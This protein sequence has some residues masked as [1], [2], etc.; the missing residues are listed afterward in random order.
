M[1]VS[2][3][4]ELSLVL[5]LLLVPPSAA[6]RLPRA[7]PLVARR[8]A[9]APLLTLAESELA[10]ASSATATNA[11]ASQHRAG[12]VSIIGLPNVGKST[13]MNALVGEKLS[14]T[15][16]KAQ[17]TR[18]RI[19]GILSGDD[20]QIVYSDTPGVLI[21]QYKLQEGMMR[22]VQGSIND[23]DVI[24]V[25]VDIF[26]DSTFDEKLLRQLRSSTA[27]LLVL[28]NKVDL[29][30]D[31]E[32]DEAGTA[33]E[34]GSGAQ[35]SRRVTTNALGSQEELVARW[36]AEFDATVLPISARYG[37]GLDAVLERI[38]A[39]LPVHPPFYPKD[40]LSDKPEKFFAA[41][42]MREAIFGHYSQEIPYSCEVAVT[43]FK[44]GDEMIRI[45]CENKL[46]R[47]PR[48]LRRVRTGY[49]YQP[50]AL[51][52]YRRRRAACPRGRAYGTC[53]VH[54]PASGVRYAPRTVA[55][56]RCRWR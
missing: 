14:I 38:K 28:L 40:Q 5:L 25:V 4:R 8:V 37:E 35:R 41:E 26:Q 23:A 45:A 22:F 27:A 6:W 53:W 50:P 29:L 21:P 47:T 9:R 43:R 13:L 7:V 36:E 31:E 24:V 32:V 2:F 33:A 20:Y 3:A 15:C 52:T 44:E 16:S 55:P 10:T 19:M 39:L 51:G 30:P 12:F 11:A 48:G 56:W 17:T 49:A 34:D 46:T 1:T 54:V 42:M 18:H